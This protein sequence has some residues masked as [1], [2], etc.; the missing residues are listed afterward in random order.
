MKTLKLY[1]LCN[2]ERAFIIILSVLGAMFWKKKQLWWIFIWNPTSK[3]RRMLD[4]Q[5]VRW[6]H[7]K[8]GGSRTPLRDFPGHVRCA[9]IWWCD[10]GYLLEIGYNTCQTESIYSWLTLRNPEHRSWSNNLSGITLIFVLARHCRRSF[11]A[12]YVHAIRRYFVYL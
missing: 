1:P 4:E 8:W 3:W 6:V 2:L 12:I 11:K 9:I 7:L 5:Q 10:V